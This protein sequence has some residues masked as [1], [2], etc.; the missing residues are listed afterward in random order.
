VTSEAGVLVTQAMEK[1]EIIN[2]FLPSSSTSKTSLQE[3]QAPTTREKVWSKEDIPLVE[4]DQLRE[5]I[6]RV[7]KR[8]S[9]GPD[10]M[11]P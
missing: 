9:M 2:A 1:A 11:H 8:K 10:G 5:Y 7:D 6:N 3:S 4:M